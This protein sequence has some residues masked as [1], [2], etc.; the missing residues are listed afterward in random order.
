VVEQRTV[1]RPATAADIAAA[2]DQTFEATSTSEEAVVSKTARVVG[3]V[4]VKVGE[5][6]REEKVTGT[7]KKTNVE[8]D[9][10]DTPPRNRY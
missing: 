7:V 9:E 5:T 10:D 6:A 1:D 4:A 2:R 3:E 8:V